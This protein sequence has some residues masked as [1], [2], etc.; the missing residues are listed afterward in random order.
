MEFGIL[1]ND[2]RPTIFEMA[3]RHLGNEDEADDV[4][5]DTL[6]KLWCMRDR[7]GQYRS[8]K[9]LA[10]VIARRLCIDR[11]RS[12]KAISIEDVSFV[13]Y[14]D[15]PED[16]IM[17]QEERDRIEHVVSSLPDGL[18]TVLRLKHIEG[19]ETVEIAQMLGSS[20]VSIRVALSRARRR[21]RDMFLTQ[22]R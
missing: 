6:L 11:L 21:V 19:M 20:E 15:S 18:Q 10:I 17:R 3:W 1:A 12:I 16:A 8:V 14:D 13:G 5:Q 22:K 7:L 2:I 4:A 9:A